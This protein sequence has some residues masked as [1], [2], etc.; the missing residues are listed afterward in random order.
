MVVPT[1]IGVTKP[2]LL[3]VAT[4]VLDEIQGNE[5]ALVP[6]PFKLVG[7]KAFKQVNKLPLIDGKE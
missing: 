6:E 7:D 5:A 1:D 2:L 4:E 3:I